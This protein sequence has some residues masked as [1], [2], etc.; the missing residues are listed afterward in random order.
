MAELVCNLPSID[1]YVRKEY[2]RDNQDSH[3]KFVKG[4]WVSAKSIPGRAFYF[5]T[6]LPDYGALY[7]KLPISAF[8]SKPKTPEVDL[9]LPNL[10]FWN[11]MDYNVIACHKQFIG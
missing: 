1:V 10:Q 9:N 7:D 5:E 2:L 8:L 3:G 4:V 11:C 6:F